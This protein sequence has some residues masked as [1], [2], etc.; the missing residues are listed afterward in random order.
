MK[1]V[2]ILLTLLSCITFITA[3]GLN[4]HADFIKTVYQS[5]YE[6]NLKEYALNEW[7]DDFTMVVYEIN[8]QADAIFELIESFESEHTNIA[9]RAIQEWS[10]DGYL[11]HNIKIFE[12]MESFGLQDLLKIHCD[13]TMVKYEY[14]NQVKAKNSF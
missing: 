4:T 1:R 7:E 14:T 13:W 8:K 3:A 2:I 10:T 5:E 6:S 9:F 12:E 11:R